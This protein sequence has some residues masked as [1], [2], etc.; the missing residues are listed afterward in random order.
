MPSQNKVRP[1]AA[2]PAASRPPP[3]RAWVVT[4][5]M[6]LGHQRAAWPLRDLAEGGVMTI[7]RAGSTPPGEQKLWERLRR[8]YEFLSRTKQWPVI[9]N[10]V[11][12]VLDRLQNIP[13]FYP[14][15]DMS[16]PSYQVM[17]LKRLIQRGLCGGML[18]ATGTRPLPLLTTFY[19]P[20]IA[21]DMAGRSRIYCV[22]CDA[23]VNRAWVAENPLKSRIVYLVPSGRTVGRLKQYGVPDE[24][25]WV[26]GFPCQ[27]NCWVTAASRCSAATWASACTAWTRETGSG[28]CTGTKPST[29]SGQP[30]AGRPGTRPS[31]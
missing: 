8:S 9:G 30:T 29:T 3:V 20:A 16:N 14:I 12:G 1:E 13:P 22:I 28:R 31:G 23:E 18:E 6:G 7:G 4:A 2:A 10:A 26:T 25:I 27:R 5:D 15:R 11:F 21:A 17:W 19:A 24:R